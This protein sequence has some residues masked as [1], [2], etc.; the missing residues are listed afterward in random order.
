G[1]AV[2]RA[3]LL[4]DPAH[5]RTADRRGP[6][7]GDAVD[8]HHPPAL[9]RLRLELHGGLARREEADL[10]PADER[11]EEHEQR[12]G[13]RE[14]RDQDRGTEPEA[15]DQHH[16]TRGIRLVRDRERSDERADT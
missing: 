2:P 3:E 5:E 14:R 1:E 13:G 4:A 12:D 10:A 7:N 16:S 6:E 11:D 8:G 15:A 9:R